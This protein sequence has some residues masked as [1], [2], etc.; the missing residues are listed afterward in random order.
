M[1]T[2]AD[3]CGDIGGMGAS[4]SC[5]LSCETWKGWVKEG[6]EG[7]VPDVCASVAS[8]D[9]TE[10]RMRES[11][12]SV[13]QEKACQQL[14]KQQTHFTTAYSRAP[15]GGARV[16]L[17]ADELLTSSLQASEAWASERNQQRQ[18]A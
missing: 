8:D 12:S 1:L 9:S 7:D 3:V 5:L 11:T 4:N 2:Y 6:G 14:G 13:L 10:V 18:E 15:L 17:Q 16:S